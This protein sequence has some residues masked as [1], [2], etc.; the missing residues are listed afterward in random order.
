MAD[1]ISFD[2]AIRAAG[3]NCSLMIANG[4]SIKHFKYANLLEKAGL[5]TGSSLRILFDALSTVDFEIV[6]RALEGAA[7]VERTYRKEARANLL[8]S[9]A[10]KLRRAMVHAVRV[11]HPA[12]REDIAKD[13]PACIKFLSQFDRVFTLNYDLLLYWV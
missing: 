5:D 7:L 4:F 11:T 3:K 12:H 10:D 9:E 8:S 2:Q 13:I 1:I 6:I